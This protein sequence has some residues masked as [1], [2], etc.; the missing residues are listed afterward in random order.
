MGFGCNEFHAL[1]L[2]EFMIYFTQK[3]QPPTRWMLPDMVNQLSVRAAYPVGRQGRHYFFGLLFLLSK[4][5]SSATRNVPP[6][7]NNVKTSYVSIRSTSLL[8]YV[9]QG[10]IKIRK[11]NNH[12]VHGYSCQYSISISQRKQLLYFLISYLLLSSN[13]VIVR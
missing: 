7:N 5:A 12:P 9:P 1:H 6:K 8:L 10:N 11:A 3:E 13:F 4:Q 2:G